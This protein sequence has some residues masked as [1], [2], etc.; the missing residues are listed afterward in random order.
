VAVIMIGGLDMAGQCAVVAVAITTDGTKVPIGLWLGDTENKPVVIGLLADLA[1]P[2]VSADRG[3]LAVLDGAKALAAA[4]KKV[5]DDKAQIQRCT[6]HKRRNVKGYLPKELGSKIDSR[7]AR[8]FADP[9]PAKAQRPPSG[10]PASS[11][12]TIPS[13]R[14]ACSKASTRCSSSAASAA[15]GWPPR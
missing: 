2:G 4:V 7:L 1:A 3:L 10:S 12:L 13:R 14:P 8:V 11:R 5:F 9:D 15:A 6:L